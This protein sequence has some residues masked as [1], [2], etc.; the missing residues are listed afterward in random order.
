MGNLGVKIRIQIKKE[1]SEGREEERSDRGNRGK[2]GKR[3][4]KR[5]RVKGEKHGVRGEGT[6]IKGKKE[7]SWRIMNNDVIV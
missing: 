4:T 7:V 5:R 3:E 2:G 1:K 6:R